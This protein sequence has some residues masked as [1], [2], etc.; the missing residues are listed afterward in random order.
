LSGLAGTGED[1][2]LPSHFPRLTLSSGKSTIA[3]T[4]AERAD[5]AGIN[6]ISFFFSRHTAERALVTGLVRTLAHRLAQVSAPAR[7]MILQTMRYDDQV[8]DK[9]LEEQTR[10]LLAD[11]LKSALQSPGIL[12]FVVDAL[13]ESDKDQELKLE[14]V[15]SI[16]I[17]LSFR[18]AGRLK[19]FITSRMEWPIQRMLQD[20]FSEAESEVGRELRLHDIDQDVVS[21]DIRTYITAGLAD[22]RRRHASRRFLEKYG[23]PTADD[24]D[25][26]VAASGVL[27][28]FAS[29]V[30]RFLDHRVVSPIHRLKEILDRS[31]TSG[32]GFPYKTLDGLYLDILVRTADDDPGTARHI[33]FVLSAITAIRS[34]VSVSGLSNLL[35][36]ELSGLYPIL[37]ALGSILVIPEEESADPIKTF[38]PS[39]SDFLGDSARCTDQRFALSR[40]IRQL[41]VATAAL[42]NMNA[43]TRERLLWTPDEG[44]TAA[45]LGLWFWF[46]YLISGTQ[47]LSDTNYRNST[48]SLELEDVLSEFCNENLFHWVKMNF[49]LD[50]WNTFAHR[51]GNDEFPDWKPVRLHEL[52]HKDY[53]QYSLT[54]LSHRHR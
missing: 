46:P 27:F 52:P 23:W 38:H 6:V 29:T 24:I 20:I 42:R 51:F 49:S 9:D 10:R 19:F 1:S 47:H 5:N 22:V 3:R 28:I 17:P 13:D 37:V 44:E 43:L 34:D 16:I 39:F 32:V 48:I 50:G 33:R 7:D 35:G 8:A 54:R 53:H 26:L 18:S 36:L 2:A 11:P 40:E 31:H 4:V 30:I 25:R 45:T 21:S 15:L 14:T 12:I 41:H